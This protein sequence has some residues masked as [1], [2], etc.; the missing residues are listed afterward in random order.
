[1]TVSASDVEPRVEP[2]TSCGWTETPS[3]PGHPRATRQTTCTCADWIGRSR[4][5]LFSLV[6]PPR[7]TGRAAC[8]HTSGEPPLSLPGRE[9]WRAAAGEIE[10]YV[11]RWGVDPRETPAAATDAQLD[12]L[13]VVRELVAATEL[14][15]Q[16]VAAVGGVDL[17]QRDRRRPPALSRASRSARRLPWAASV[18]TVSA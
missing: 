3:S 4:N 5:E 11:A 17:D 18:A 9:T 10:S 6:S 15:I 7:S 1:M 2:C 13:A 16:R 8:W 14:P 12:H